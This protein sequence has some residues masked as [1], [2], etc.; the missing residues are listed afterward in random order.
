MLLR[1][2][3]WGGTKQLCDS[4]KNINKK[5]IISPVTEWCKSE[6]DRNKYIDDINLLHKNLNNHEIA[7]KGSAFGFD[8]SLIKNVMNNTLDNQN[9]K[10]IWGF[11][12]EESWTKNEYHKMMDDLIMNNKNQFY[13]RKCYQAYLK[14]EWEKLIED[15]DLYGDKYF[16]RLVRGAY[17]Q[18]EMKIDDKNRKVFSDKRYTDEQFRDMMWYLISEC[19]NNVVIATHNLEDIEWLKKN[20]DINNDRIKIGQLMGLGLDLYDP[21][22]IKYI[23]YGN[24]IDALPYLSRRLI[25]NRSIMRYIL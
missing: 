18:A 7:I 5:V 21:Q 9:N 6:E 25:E 11:D 13:I 8:T 1:Y 15:I 14:G 20:I 23:P 12:A 16:I 4:V 19:N 3:I 10:N 17:H 24:L 2:F 22:V